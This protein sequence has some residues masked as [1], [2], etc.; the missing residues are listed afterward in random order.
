MG[1][2]HQHTI[3]TTDW[4]QARVLLFLVVLI[5]TVLLSSC[6]GI[7]TRAESIDPTSL[8]TDVTV[9][10]QPV[11]QPRQLYQSEDRNSV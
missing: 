5:L 8:P 10:E 4:K 3:K 7:R 2:F 6:A 1:T 9:T 11:E